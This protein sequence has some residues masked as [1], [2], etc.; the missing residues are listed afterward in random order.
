MPGG[1][2]AAHKG[3]HGKRQ[4]ACYENRAGAKSIH[5]PAAGNE[6]YRERDGVAADDP[7]PIGN[8][9]TECGADRG[10]RYVHGHHVEQREEHRHAQDDEVKQAWAAALPFIRS[11][12]KGLW[13]L[14]CGHV[15]Q[16]KA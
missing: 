3:C 15:L 12:R 9:H 11:V 2:E 13:M 8:G 4:D 16:D 14:R 1:C 5:Q 10:H 7:G 6:E